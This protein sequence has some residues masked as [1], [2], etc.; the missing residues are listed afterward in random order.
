MDLQ[1]GFRFFLG[2]FILIT[3]LLAVVYSYWWLIL[4]MFIGIALVQSAFTG[5]CPLL[6]VLEKF[7]FKSSESTSCKP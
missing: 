6:I 2:I 1:K 7:G 3:L 5:F 4:T